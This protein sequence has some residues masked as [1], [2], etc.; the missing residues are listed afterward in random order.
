MM[1]VIPTAS[2]IN[3]LSMDA[4]IKELNRKSSH[5]ICS[6]GQGLIKNVL[7][8]GNMVPINYLSHFSRKDIWG[9]NY[10]SCNENIW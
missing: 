10:F 8:K 2:Q 4:L 3:I 1:H 6:I 5:K 7:E 9:D